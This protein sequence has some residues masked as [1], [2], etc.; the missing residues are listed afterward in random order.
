MLAVKLS[1]A[2]MDDYWDNVD[3]I[4]RNQL[5]EQQF[6]DLRAMRK[7][8]GGDTKNDALLERFVG[9]CG[10]G[11]PTAIKPEI[12]A[13]ASLSTAAALYYAWHGITRFDHGL[14]QVNLFLNR[15]SPWMDV[16]S[17][18]PFEGKVILRNKQAEAV[19]VRI[20]VWVDVKNLKVMLNGKPIE[21]IQPGRC[22]MVEGIKSGDVIELKFMVRERTDKYFIHDKT[23]TIQYRGST[24][25]DIS[26]RNTDPKLM[27]MYQRGGMKGT[28]APM[29]KVKRF[30]AKNLLPLQ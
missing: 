16:E 11:E 9:G 27:P 7:M 8:A 20:P 6:T 14:A 15:A 5:I 25:V 2:G 13:T 3:A 19:R 22:V 26:P 12:S 23:Y 21:A 30:V 18:L 4:V 29:H 24:V 10:A 17:Y 1:D 28:K